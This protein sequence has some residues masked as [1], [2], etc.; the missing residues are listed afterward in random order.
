MPIDLFHAL[1]RTQVWTHFGALRPSGPAQAVAGHRLTPELLRADDANNDV[2]ADGIHR[3]LLAQ[4]ALP[5]TP[6]LAV[7][8]RAGVHAADA[9]LQLAFRTDP[10]GDPRLLVQAKRIVSAYLADLVSADR[11]RA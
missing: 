6:D 9:V 7:A 5:D 4:E 8:T 10:H 2:V 11:P 3:V 1:D